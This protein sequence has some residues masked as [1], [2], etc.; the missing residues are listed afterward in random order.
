MERD[1]LDRWR[2]WDFIVNVLLIGVTLLTL[3][4]V[5]WS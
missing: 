5:A 1:E 4:S 2:V 3:A